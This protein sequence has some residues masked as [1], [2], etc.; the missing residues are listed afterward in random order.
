[1]KNLALNNISQIF[2]FFST[3]EALK[4]REREREREREKQLLSKKKRVE[5]EERE[6]VGSRGKTEKAKHSI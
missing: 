6:R 1:L 3:I 4:E 5:E 2:I